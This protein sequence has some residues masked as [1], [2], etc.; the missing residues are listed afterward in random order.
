MHSLMLLDVEEML[1]L[2]TKKKPG[3]LTPPAGSQLILDMQLKPGL[4]QS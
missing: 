4:M 2:Q 3:S 1:R